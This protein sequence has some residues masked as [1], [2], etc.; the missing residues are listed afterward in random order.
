MD[1]LDRL[2]IFGPGYVYLILIRNL[3]VLSQKEETATFP[4]SLPNQVAGSFTVE[5]CIKELL[6]NFFRP[7]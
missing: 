1:L 7:L 6:T 3:S 5:N 4:T 2:D